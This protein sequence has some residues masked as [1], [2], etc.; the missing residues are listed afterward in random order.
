[1]NDPTSAGDDRHSAYFDAMRDANQ[2]LADALGHLRAE[3][4]VG[5]ITPAQAAAER[6]GLL[7]RHLAECK[8]L[9]REL[10]GDTAP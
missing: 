4:D 6:I 1:M 9:R 3:E 8:R 5:R 2:V 10:L 7:E